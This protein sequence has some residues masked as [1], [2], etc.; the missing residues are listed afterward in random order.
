MARLLALITLKEHLTCVF[1]AR[2]RNSTTSCYDLDIDSY[3][4]MD[5]VPCGSAGYSSLGTVFASIVVCA[6]LFVAHNM[7]EL[8]PSQLAFV[9]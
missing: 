8:A 3:R 6:I 5:G 4:S 7:V 2:I 1:L 9:V